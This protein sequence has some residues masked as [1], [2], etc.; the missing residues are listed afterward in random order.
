MVNKN[1]GLGRTMTKLHKYLVNI[2][3][4]S[5]RKDVLAAV[6]KENRRSKTMPVTFAG[7]TCWDGTHKESKVTSVNQLDLETVWCRMYGYYGVDKELFK[8]DLILLFHLMSGMSSGN[9]KEEWSQLKWFPSQV[10]I[11]F[12]FELFNQC[13]CFKNLAAPFF[14]MYQPR[15]LAKEISRKGRK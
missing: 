6:Q 10:K 9:V 2:S 4:S 5:L 15:F 14:E 3:Q 7:K 12:H 11:C 13:I 8:K 1:P